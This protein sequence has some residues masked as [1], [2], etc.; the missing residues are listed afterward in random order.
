MVL[1]LRDVTDGGVGGEVWGV[2]AVVI[3]GTCRGYN[4]LSWGGLNRLRLVLSWECYR[5]C[6]MS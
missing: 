1:E 2:G 4:Q 5:C 3:C 6:M